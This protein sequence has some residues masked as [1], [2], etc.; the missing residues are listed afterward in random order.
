MKKVLC[1]IA[2]GLTLL[3]GPGPAPR[4]ES[5]ELL[6]TEEG[7][8]A[9]LRDGE[10]QL[11]PYESFSSYPNGNLEFHLTDGSW[12]ICGPGGTVLYDDI[13]AMYSDCH[14]ETLLEDGTTLYRYFSLSGDLMLEG[15]GEDYAGWH[16]TGLAGCFFRLEE[17]STLVRNFAAGQEVRLPCRA[18]FSTFTTEMAETT[19][20]ILF[21]D[22]KNQRSY[23]VDDDLTVS[24]L[25]G[26]F[27]F[28]PECEEVYLTRSDRTPCALYG[29]PLPQS[30]EEKETVE[31]E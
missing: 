17:G 29:T 11:L 9:V 28:V 6:V 14:T 15:A 25:E 30:T 8:R 26:F 22:Y 10:G 2:A 24:E 4:A 31:N 13:D 1:C 18:D 16:D 12:V 23:L 3:L 5:A 21:G 20:R 7:G 19:G 27:C